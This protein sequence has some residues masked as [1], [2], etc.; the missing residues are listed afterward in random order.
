MSTYSFRTPAKGLG[1]W[2]ALFAL[3]L[4]C[5]FVR[6]LLELADAAPAYVAGLQDEAARY[7]LAVAGLVSLAGIAAHLWAIVALFRKKRALTVAYATLL[8][9]TLAGP[10][11]L[12]P[13][14]AVAG[15]GPEAAL[16]DAYIAKV[17]VIVI[18]MACWYRYLCVSVRV[19]NTL[20]N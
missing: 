12:L 4:C 7:P 2:L 20:V 14:L 10:F 6:S 15:P 16:A 3:G 8:T 11:S 1:G 5:G 9:L 13:L 18:I 19:R 17:I